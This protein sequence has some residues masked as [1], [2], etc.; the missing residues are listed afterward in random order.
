MRSTQLSTHGVMVSAEPKVT[1]NDAHKHTPSLHLVGAGRL[2]VCVRERES[3]R[4]L[5]VSL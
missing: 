4:V 5:S 2:C 1:L 3:E